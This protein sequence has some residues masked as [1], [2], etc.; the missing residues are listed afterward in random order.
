MSIAEWYPAP[1]V[2][3]AKTEDKVYDFKLLGWGKSV[4]I[5][6]FVLVDTRLYLSTKSVFHVIKEL[7]KK[8]L[9][10]S[11]IFEFKWHKYAN[12]GHSFIW[13]KI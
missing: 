8:S 4:S 1:Y 6:R 7:R 5:K 9:F 13:S 3:L 11:N 12:V 2:V 10:V